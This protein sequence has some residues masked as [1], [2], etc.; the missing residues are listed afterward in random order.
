MK[1]ILKSL[2]MASLLLSLVT[3]VRAENEEWKGKEKTKMMQEKKEKYHQKRLEKLTKELELTKEQGEKVSQ[4]MKDGWGKIKV[5]KKKMREKVQAIRKG[6][7]SQIE[8]TLT[9]E[10]SKK[11]KKHKKELRE[12]RKNKMKKLQKKGKKQGKHFESEYCK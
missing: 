10:Q 7:D 8:K 9:P 5:E 3:G 2:L 4:I 6:I 1:T 12:R 11:F